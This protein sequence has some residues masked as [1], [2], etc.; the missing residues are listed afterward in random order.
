MTIGRQQN[1]VKNF[2]NGTLVFIKKWHNKYD[3]TIEKEVTNKIKIIDLIIIQKTLSL[4]KSSTKFSALI[5]LKIKYMIG[6]DTA[7]ATIVESAECQ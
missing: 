5:A 2:L 4:N 6:I 3:I 7:V 1:T